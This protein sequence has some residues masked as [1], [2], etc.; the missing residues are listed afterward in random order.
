MKIGDGGWYHRYLLF[1]KK[2]MLLC[3]TLQSIFNPIGYQ[4]ETECTLMIISNKAT[5]TPSSGLTRGNDDTRQK[6]FDTWYLTILSLASPLFLVNANSYSSNALHPGSHC[7]VFFFFFFFTSGLPNELSFKIL[8][9]QVSISILMVPLQKFMAVVHMT[10]ITCT[11]L[12][13]SPSDPNVCLLQWLRR[14]VYASKEMLVWC[15]H[16]CERL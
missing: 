15:L 11:S 7:C 16:H 10:Y 5:N 6:W 4:M 1:L 13:P 3:T 12:V 2:T 8:S 14:L 9:N